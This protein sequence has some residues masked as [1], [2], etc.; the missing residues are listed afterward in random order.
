MLQKEE[1]VTKPQ[2]K[3]ATNEG[4]PSISFICRNR[5]DNCY[6]YFIIVFCHG[7]RITPNCKLSSVLD[8][9]QHNIICFLKVRQDETILGIFLQ[10]FA[11]F[12]A[13]IL[14]VL[15]QAFNRSADMRLGGACVQVT[16]H[17]GDR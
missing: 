5:P 2:Q 10:A 4:S 17:P 13:E 11:A 16:V 6:R 14:L 1:I 7:Y 3:W 12:K 15:Y 8:G 9:V